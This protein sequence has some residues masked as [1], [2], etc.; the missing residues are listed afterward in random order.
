MPIYIPVYAGHR[1]ANRLSSLCSLPG[2]GT[3]VACVGN[4]LNQPHTHTHTHA[5][6]KKKAFIHF[7]SALDMY[8]TFSPQEAACFFLPPSVRPGQFSALDS[9]LHGI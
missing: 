5:H 6:K 7:C 2:A 8:D 3:Y 9:G 1:F 4:P